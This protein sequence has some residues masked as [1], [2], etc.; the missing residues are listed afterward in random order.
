MKNTLLILSFLL[1]SF[2]IFGQNLVINEFMSSNEATLQDKDGDYNDWI[3]LYNTTNTTINLLGF[4]LS[5]DDADL[6]KWSF[7]DLD[8]LPNSFILVFASDKNRLNI[9]ELHTN[10]KITSGG[11]SLFLSNESGVVIDQS[12]SIELSSDESYGR[13][14]DGGSAWGIINIPTP[15]STNNNSNSLSFSHKEGFHTSS[16]PLSINSLAGDDIHYTLNG[17]KPTENSSKLTGAI[18]LT[19]IPTTPDQ[20][21]ISYKGWESPSK[22]IH[23]ATVL[24][25]ASFKDGVRT[26]K[27]Y[28]KTFFV[29][30]E[31]LDMYTIPVISLITPKENLF[32][33]D[34]GI[35]VP[36]DNYNDEKPEWT[37]NYFM[38]GEE[39]ERDIHIEYFATNGELG[40][41][42]DAG[43]TKTSCPK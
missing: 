19:D 33:D 11:E 38:R 5:D 16:F 37:G 24:R 7:P 36:G 39:W 2:Y 25:C 22:S 28:T 29:D 31:I 34:K 23:K 32:S 15:N 27:I 13:I 6:E 41:A 9:D 10:F 4:S 17:D 3:E 20:E 14:P 18:T 12:I 1:T 26:S 21:L 42:Q 43:I 35:F 8:I 40:F 30:T